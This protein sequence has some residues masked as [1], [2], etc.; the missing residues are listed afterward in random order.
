M[1]KMIQYS[2]LGVAL[3]VLLSPME[4]HAENT[5]QRIVELEKRVT[6][7]QEQVTELQERAAALQ[8]QVAILDPLPTQNEDSSESV[9]PKTTG[10]SNVRENWLSLEMG[11]TK[12]QV[13]QL[14]GEPTAVRAMP[15]GHNWFYESGYAM[16]DH[17]GRLERWSKPL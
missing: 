3:L 12:K 14:L 4:I 5:E 17:M 1:K 10:K 16:F 6:K 9:K 7:L 11:M 2:T 15:Y 8:K 13:V